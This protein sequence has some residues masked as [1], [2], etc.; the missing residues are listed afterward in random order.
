MYHTASLAHDDVLDRADL[1]RGKASLNR[2][3]GQKKSIWAG[4]YTMAIA[5]KIVGQTGNTEV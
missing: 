4:N 3:C 2:L 5:N 1:R